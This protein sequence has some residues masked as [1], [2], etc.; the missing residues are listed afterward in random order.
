[1]AHETLFRINI[2]CNLIYVGSRADFT[3]EGVDFDRRRAA[4]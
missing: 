3:L 4:H 2:A 1:M